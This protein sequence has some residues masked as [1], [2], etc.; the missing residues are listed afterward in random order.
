MMAIPPITP[1]EFQQLSVLL[2]DQCGLYLQE[3][4]AYLIETRLRDFVQ[5]LGLAGYGELYLRLRY[6][7]ERLLPTVINLMTTNETLWFRDESCWNAV[8]KAILPALLQKL[9]RGS[10]RVKVWIAG[11]ST[12]QE[13]YSLAMLI[14]EVCLKRGSPELA[15]YFD[16]QAMDISLAALD[17]ARSGRYNDFD[18]RRGLSEARR[19]RYFERQADNRWLLRPHIRLRVRFDAI[20]LTRDF[21]WLGKFDLIFC[22]NVT[23]YFTPPVRE[24]ILAQMAAMLEPG[25]ALLLGATES[26]WGGRGSFRTVE[27]E[28]CIFIS[29]PG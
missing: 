24:R 29:K 18:I 6:E 5:S 20:N 26:V 8:E 27:F 23:I 25:G 15:R 14:D 21:S 10:G 19:G 3:D 9:E 2:R 28:G 11:C 17:L 12:G 4:Q 13:A 22:R 1:L 7:P 16:I